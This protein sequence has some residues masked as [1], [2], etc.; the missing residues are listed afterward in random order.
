MGEIK[1]DQERMR[2]QCSQMISK[3]KEKDLQ[4][5]K[6]EETKEI[7][8]AYDGHCQSLYETYLSKHGKIRERM[9]GLDK[10]TDTN[11]LKNVLKEIYSDLTHIENEWYDNLANEHEMI[12]PICLKIEV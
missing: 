2:D 3:I 9:D 4:A 6:M 7:A 10:E 1:S 5:R 12:R 8:N 11:D